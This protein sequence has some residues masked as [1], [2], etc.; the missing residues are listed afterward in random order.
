MRSKLTTGAALAAAVGILTACSGGDGNSDDVVQVT[1]NNHPWTDVILERI[2]EFE[3]ATGLQVETSVLGEDQLSDQYNVRLNSGSS[4]MDVMMLRPLQELKMFSSNG[5]LMPLDERIEGSEIGWDDFQMQGPVTTDDGVM[6]VPI[7]SEQTVLYYRKDLLAEAGLE[8][9][10]TFEE[11]E[12]A[13]AQIESENDDIYGFVA[14]GQR[15]AA[16]TQFAGYLYGFGGSWDDGAGTATLDTPEAHAAYE[17]Y[18]SMLLD[19]G[20]PGATNMSW[21]EA[22]AIF[23]QGQAA[24][25]SDGSVFYNNMI[26]PEQSRIGDVIG[27]AQLPGGAAGSRPTSVPS[28]A[29]A[30]N[31]NAD[32]VDGAWQFI[33]WATSP[34]M[35]RDV[36]LEGVPGARQSVWDDEDSLSAFPDDLAET[37][38]NSVRDGVDFDRPMVVEVGEARDI[39]GAPLAAMLDGQDLEAALATAQEQYQ[40]LLD[41][42]AER[43]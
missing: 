11:L 16:V 28:W 10:T 6:A 31:N 1:L 41:E 3:E 4:D 43:F 34:E 35:V 24:F 42:D 40:A 14:R 8:V 26:D 22:S 29:L 32:N 21:Q 9:P 5:W 17:F 12:E 7:V 19:H 18:G 27:C 23:Q 33:E 39:V 20:P 38:T 15:A 13:A 30:I 37:L 25:Y 2:P 36:Q